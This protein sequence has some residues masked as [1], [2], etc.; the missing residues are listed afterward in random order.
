MRKHTVSLILATL[1]L[2]GAG[3]VAFAA[4]AVLGNSGEVYKVRSGPL[5]ELNGTSPSPDGSGSAPA[6]GPPALAV[7]V[8]LP[9]SGEVETFIVPGSQGGAVET[10]RLMLFED[11]SE[12]LY[13]FW[14]SLR[15]NGSREL[16]LAALAE[17]EWQDAAEVEGSPEAFR[18][19]QGYTV[20]NDF[21]EIALSP[22]ETVEVRRTILHLTW[23]DIQQIDGSDE[24]VHMYTP[25]IFADGSYIGWNP[26]FVLND[27]DPAEAPAEPR[28]LT[29]QLLSSASLR[30]GVDS[31]TIIATFANARSQQLL[32]LEIEVLPLELGH[33]GDEIR[34]QIINMGSLFDGGDIASLVDE[35]RA[36]IINMGSTYN[37]AFLDYLAG[38][39]GTFVSTHAATVPDIDTLATEVRDLAIDTGAALISHRFGQTVTG[40]STIIELDLSGLQIPDSQGGSSPGSINEPT[41]ILDLRLR[42]AVSAP[43]TGD[44]PTHFYSSATGGKILTAWEDEEALHYQQSSNEGWSD[45]RSLVLNENLGLSEAHGLL[46]RKADR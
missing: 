10:P 17:G 43:D 14:E 1:L 3:S 29:Q 32:S 25:I 11:S 39:V 18:S 22:E 13:L 15:A 28:A 44:G 4:D 6:S 24:L 30:Q 41:Q 19:D 45:T 42:A 37:P 34:A 26:V 23:S 9:A 20:T 31:R 5:N 36:Q 16:H 46:K 35:I 7:D 21:F 27:F 33:L 12:T 38:E 8:L 2:T 40:G